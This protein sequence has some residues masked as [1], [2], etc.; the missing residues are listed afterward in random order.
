MDRARCPLQSLKIKHE[1][2]LLSSTHP[3][4][5]RATPLARPSSSAAIHNQIRLQ[6]LGAAPPT[7]L[8]S[9]IARNAFYRVRCIGVGA[10]QQRQPAEAGVAG[11]RVVAGD[12]WT[13][14]SAAAHL[15]AADRKNGIS[16]PRV[17]PSI[18]LIPILSCSLS[19]NATYTRS[20]VHCSS[21]HQRQ[22]PSITHRKQTAVPCS[23]FYRRRSA[24]SRRRHLKGPQGCC[25]VPE[26]PH[27]LRE[28]PGCGARLEP[29][30]IFFRFIQR[31]LDCDHQ[32]WN[33]V[34]R[35]VVCR[36]NHD[37]VCAGRQDSLLHVPFLLA[38]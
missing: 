3:N 31:W 34:G 23:G 4:R 17:L 10:Q 12:Q 30:D 6:T 15:G 24:Y 1:S 8:L 5:H 32:R 35:S 38:N 36:I 11:N 25:A 7:E 33:G 19:P 28:R 26:S 9:L 21:H 14:A 22:W 2:R 20:A 37:K 27:C 29:R 16:Q 13:V 18:L